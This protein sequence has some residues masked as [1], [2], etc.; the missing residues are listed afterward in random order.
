MSSG[1]WP[2]RPA[3]SYG[4]SIL[5]PLSRYTTPTS[6]IVNRAHSMLSEYADGNY[7][8]VQ[9]Q[10]PYPYPSQPVYYQDYDQNIS[11]GY[12]APDQQKQQIG[13]LSTTTMSNQVQLSNPQP[14]TVPA[15]PKNR[16]TLANMEE[17]NDELNDFINDPTTKT[18]ERNRKYQKTNNQY[19]MNHMMNHSTSRSIIIIII[20]T[21]KVSE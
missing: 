16:R 1:P 13:T 14:V 8:P 6:M 3:S 19:A 18:I 11:Y 9:P 21:K 5:R 12:S 10:H 7:Y 2:L 20:I 15:T 17:E 4:P